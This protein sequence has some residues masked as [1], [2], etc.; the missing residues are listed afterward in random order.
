MA[1]L[2][3]KNILEYLDCVQF[4]RRVQLV[5]GDFSI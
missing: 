2:Y 1:L 3:E 4:C 5:T